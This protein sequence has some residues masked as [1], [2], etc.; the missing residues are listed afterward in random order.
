MYGNFKEN[1][2]LKYNFVE[3]KSRIFTIII[4]TSS[5][6]QTMAMT[7][8]SLLTY[9]NQAIGKLVRATRSENGNSAGKRNPAT[10][11][12]NEK[13]WFPLRLGYE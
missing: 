5:L 6:L 12:V 3:T 7:H 10:G 1:N 8:R 4:S 13:V 9:E 2:L 11:L